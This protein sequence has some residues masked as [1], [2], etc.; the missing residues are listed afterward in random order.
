MIDPKTLVMYPPFVC[1]VLARRTVVENGKRKV[2]P[3]SSEEIAVNAQIPHR[4]VLWISSQPNWFEVR[5]GDAIRFMS[6]CGITNRNMWRN[7]WFLARSIGKAGGFAHLDQLPRVDRQRV[8]RM[9]VRHL[10]KW[11]ESVKEIYGK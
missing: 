7:R 3:I 11:Q 10:N 4:R 8:S 1:R 6:A 2:V 9:F 5:V